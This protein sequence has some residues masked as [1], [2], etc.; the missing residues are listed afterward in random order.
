MLF[1]ERANAGSWHGATE[2][3]ASLLT[4][5][6]DRWE[7]G[8]LTVMEEHLA[9]A[10][11]QRGLAVVVE[12]IPIGADAPLCLLAT[13]EGNEH[14]LGLSLVELC[15]REAGWRA[16]WAGS[17]TPTAEVVARIAR[18]ELDGVA[19]SAAANAPDPAALAAIASTVGQACQTAGAHLFMG[20][21]GEWPE[22]PTYGVRLRDLS[23]F[24]D[25]VR[26]L[27]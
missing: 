21:A 7:T 9:S 20:G 18:G 12:A 3:L 6:G 16:E 1:E 13:A 24:Y 23:R 27:G 14:T 17:R 4:E 25:A 10:T 26:Q 5:I 15:L 8:R 11:L 22:A 19:L 2:R